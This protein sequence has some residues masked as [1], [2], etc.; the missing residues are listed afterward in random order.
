M[1][2]DLALLTLANSNQI[3]KSLIQLVFVL[4]LIVESDGHTIL[5]ALKNKK[6]SSITSSKLFLEFVSGSIHEPSF[7]DN[8]RL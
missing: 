4:S 6:T 5:F 2:K 7:F 1:R 3:W 8:S